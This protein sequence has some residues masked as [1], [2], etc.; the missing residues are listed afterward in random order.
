[1]TYVDAVDADLSETRWYQEAA[2]DKAGAVWYAFNIVTVSGG[3]RKRRVMHRAI[4]SRVLGRELSS[5]EVV[6]HIDGDG[7]NNSRSNLRLATRHENARNRTANLNGSGYKGVSWNKNHGAW[8]ARIFLSGKNRHLGYFT[9][10]AAAA[11][12]YDI[13]ASEAFG[14]FA[15]LNRGVGSLSARPRAA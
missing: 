10:I 6:D 12:A 7:L 11:A 14:E 9:S 15:R 5:S 1:M 2:G 4:L 8:S 3:A 13:A